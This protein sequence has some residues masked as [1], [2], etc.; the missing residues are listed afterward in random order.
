MQFYL[1][2]LL[3]NITPED[4]RI[5]IPPCRVVILSSDSDYR[6][7]KTQIFPAILKNVF[8]LSFGSPRYIQMEER[9]NR[10]IWLSVESYQFKALKLST[11]CQPVSYCLAVLMV[12]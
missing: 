8:P 11:D 6:H 1:Q 3:K 12:V 7:P 4:M 2:K 9:T 10:L 5:D